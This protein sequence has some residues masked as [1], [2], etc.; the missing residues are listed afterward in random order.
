MFL[1]RIHSFVQAKSL[2]SYTHGVCGKVQIASLS[3]LY[4]YCTTFQEERNGKTGM[5]TA[6]VA[7]T[8][9][10][11]APVFVYSSGAA[12][13]RDPCGRHAPLRRGSMS[14]YGPA[15]AWAAALWRRTSARATS[16]RMVLTAIITAMM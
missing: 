12:Q 9:R 3:G 13:Q 5:A 14:H 15:A 4:R 2:Y 6:R 10:R 11:L 1:H 8:I 16:G 7:T